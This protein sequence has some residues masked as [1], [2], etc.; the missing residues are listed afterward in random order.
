VLGSGLD[1]RIGSPAMAMPCVVLLLV[2]AL[3]IGYS[4]ASAPAPGG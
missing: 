2:M 3:D 1:L 4:G